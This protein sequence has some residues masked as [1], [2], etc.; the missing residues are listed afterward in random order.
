MQLAA[1][2][3]QSTLHT[4]GGARVANPGQEDCFSRFRVRGSKNVGALT[5]SRACISLL[6]RTV[7][8]QPAPAII[9]KK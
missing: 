6:A 4:V 9:E 3:P 8:S 7:N 5:T 2:A 1:C